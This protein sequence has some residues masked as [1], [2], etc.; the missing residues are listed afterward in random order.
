MRP[1]NLLH[2]PSLAQQQIVFH[3]CWSSLA[4]LWVGSVM[5]WVGLHWQEN[6]IATLTQQQALLQTDLQN[7]TRQGQEAAQLQGRLRWHQEQNIQLK[8]I[9]QEQQQW[10]S[11]HESLQTEALQSGLRLERMQAIDGK[12]ELQGTLPDVRDMVNAQ[13]KLSDK[14]PH[15]LRL[16]SMTVG[17]KNQVNFVWQTRWSAS[18]TSPLLSGAS[19]PKVRP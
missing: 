12:L 13:Q 17:P 10:Q 6:Q 11:L 9:T 15:P 3:R 18:P 7:R 4:G 1:F 8:K 5:A 16:S 19:V 2:Y 14:L